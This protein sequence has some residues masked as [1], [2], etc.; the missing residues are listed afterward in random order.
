MAQLAFLYDPLFQK[1][2]PGAG[3]AEAPRRLQ[4]IIRLLQN[5]GFLNKVTVLSPQEAEP[6]FLSLV[7]A[8][9]YVNSI[10]QLRGIERYV[11]DHGDTILTEH[12]VDAALLAAGAAKTAVDLIFGDT[13]DKIF[14]AVRP[15]GHHAL[16]DRG[17]GFCIFNNIALAARY[18]LQKERVQ[19]VLIIDWDVHHG[20]GTQQI[21]YE[22]AS[23]FYLSLHQFPFY[24]RSGSAGESGRGAGEG[25][26]LNI[27]LPAGQGNDAYVRH[28]EQA[29]TVVEGRFK[30]DLVL[31]SAGFDAH[32]SD[33]LGGM[34]L[35]PEGFY[36]LTELAARF[37]Q[38]Y[39]NGRIISFLEGGYS[40]PGLAESVYEHVRCLLK[41]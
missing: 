31:L 26:T 28:L 12:S 14:A 39:C 8:S 22:D 30:P 20:N 32:A 33:P 34:R 35:T 5:N 9:S 38:R 36:K 15:P 10:L 3:H 1:H 2:D 6:S 40:Y 18:A 41:H 27:P 19:R 23:V 29:L 13:F 17:M 7:H 25:F 21:F 37:A 16:A 4:S 24:P 11:L